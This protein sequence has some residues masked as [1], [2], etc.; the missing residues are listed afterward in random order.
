MEFNVRELQARDVAPMV[1]VM[2]KIGMREIAQALS[3]ESL[4]DVVALASDPADGEDAKARAQRIE[5][6]GLSVM[7]ELATIVFANFE[8][9]EA[10][11][12]KLMASVSG[13][14]EQEVSELSLADTMDLLVAIFQSEGFSDFFKRVQ[15]LLAR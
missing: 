1:R 2:N 11:L 4:R 7:L 3:P 5:Q 8:R 15:A 13:M 6:V 10:D 12:F 14:S 9:A